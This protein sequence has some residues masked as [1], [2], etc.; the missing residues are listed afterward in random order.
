MIQLV[1]ILKV[2]LIV[3][4]FFIDHANRYEIMHRC[5]HPNPNGRPTFSDLHKLFD[6]FLS[7]H[8][9]EKYPYIE[10]DANTPYFFDRLTPQSLSDYQ[11]HMKGVLTIE[12]VLDGDKTVEYDSL[13]AH[14]S[15][16]RNAHSNNS[17]YTDNKYVE[18]G[19]NSPIDEGPRQETNNNCCPESTGPTH[20]GTHIEL[21]RLQRQCSQTE[22]ETP[23]PPYD[24]LREEESLFYDREVTEVLNSIYMLQ[25]EEDEFYDEVWQKKLSTITEVSNE[26]YQD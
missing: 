16:P 24:R 18:S 25:N 4:V 2:M 5:W 1:L 6:H 13:Q 15:F 8:T 20:L 3:T 26:D 12:D 11:A 9:Q 19:Y 7:K 22:K 23:A 10:M 14:D 17:T 21:H